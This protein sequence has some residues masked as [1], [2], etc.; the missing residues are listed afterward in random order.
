MFRKDHS[1]YMK[2]RLKGA[3][4]KWKLRDQLGP[5]S[6]DSPIKWA[7]TTAYL[8]NSKIAQMRI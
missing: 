4:A 5:G 6:Q 1:S 8:L 7:E 3:G 2:I